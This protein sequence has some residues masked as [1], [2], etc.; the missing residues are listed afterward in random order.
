MSS[1]R[2]PRRRPR[3]SPGSVADAMLIGFLEPLTNADGVRDAGGRGRDGD[4]DG[5]DPADLAR[6][7]DGRAVQSQ[8][9]IA[10]YRAVL[11]AGELLRASTRC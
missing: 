7:V 9:N 8:A 4:R 11:V 3:R 5:G 10:G 1:S 2:S 6:P